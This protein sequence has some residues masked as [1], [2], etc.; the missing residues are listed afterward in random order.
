MC[1]PTLKHVV[2][3]VMHY[4]EFLSELDKAGLSVRGFAALIGMNPN[5]I[6]NYAR[7]G[8][9]PKHLAL[10]TVLV[11]GVSEMGGDYRKIMSRVEIAPQKPRGGARPG[12][13]GG[14]RQIDLDLDE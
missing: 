12:H 7:T 11:V 10:I 1:Y 3:I 4:T 2:V 6:S 5:S 14:D 9:L 13:F 8:R